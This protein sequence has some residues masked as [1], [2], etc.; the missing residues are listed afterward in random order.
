MTASVKRVPEGHHTISP[1]LTVRDG[2]RMI[3]FYTQAFGAKEIRRSVAPDGTTLLHAE[4]EIG[5][6][7]FFLNGEFPDM[8]LVSPLSRGGTSVVVHL[9]VPDVDALYQQAVGAGAKVVMP[10]ADQF[11]G[12]RY[13]I[14]EDPSG[15]R[16]SMATH[17]KD[18]TPEQM[19]AASEAMFGDAK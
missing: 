7:K 8:N 5:D 6:S 14:V 9:Y 3:D 16:W 1:H 17:V 18:M 11:W 12:D 2:A 4:L 19:K 13:G 15:H 10:L